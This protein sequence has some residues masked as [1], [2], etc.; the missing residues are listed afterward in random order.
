MLERIRTDIVQA[1]AIRNPDRIRVERNTLFLCVHAGQRENAV[2]Q[3]TVDIA[4]CIHLVHGDAVHS[5]KLSQVVFRIQ[6]T[7]YQRLV[8]FFLGQ[9][10]AFVHPFAKL[11]IWRRIFHLRGP[12]GGVAPGLQISFLISLWNDQLE[13]CVL[14]LF[15]TGIEGILVADAVN[16]RLGWCGE[17]KRN[18]AELV[19]SRKHI[20]RH[21]TIH[22]V[23]WFFCCT[24][25]DIFERGTILEYTPADIDN[26]RLQLDLLQFGAVGKYIASDRH[27]AA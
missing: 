8:Q 22:A 27:K 12:H 13:L 10:S 3:R 16:L 6:R 7:L 25:K 5:Q 11:Q 20:I 21:Q 17:C 24:E 4:E 1:P 18:L 14:F 26:T 9:P 2:I 23:E 15:P 19:A